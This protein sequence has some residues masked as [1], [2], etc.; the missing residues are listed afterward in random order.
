MY[1]FHQLCDEHPD[2]LTTNVWVT[3]GFTYRGGEYCL[4]KEEYERR[5]CLACTFRLE[6]KINTFCLECKA[7]QPVDWT[8]G[9]KSLD[10]FIMESWSNIKN[11]CDAYIQWIEYPQLTNA[12]AMTSLRHGCTHIADWQ[13][14]RVIFKPIV[15]AQS[16]DFYQ[17]NHFTCKQCKQCCQLLLCVF[18][19]RLIDD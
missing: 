16:L 18:M 12:R 1:H 14:T 5:L 11:K 9:N 19:M 13:S 10:S 6:P 15:D 8:T 7:P 3:I 4:I 17:V 2:I